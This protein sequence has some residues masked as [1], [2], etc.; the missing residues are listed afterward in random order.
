MGKLGSEFY[1]DEVV[2]A[3]YMARRE[4]RADSPN[5]V[6]E[7]PILDELIGD[8][9]NLRILDLGCGNAE[10]GQEAFQRGCR[11]YLGIDGSENMINLAQNMLHGTSGKTERATIEE[12]EYPKSQFDLVISRLALHYIEPFESICT[13]VF[14]TLLDGGRFIFS[15]EHP[16]ITSSDQAWRT[17]GPRQHWIVDDYFE[18]G[19]RVTNWMGGDVIKYH[20][21]V[22]DYF[23]A[24]RRAK[25]VI[26]DVRES[27]PRR[28]LFGDEETYKRRKR[29]PLLLFFSAHRP[30]A[31]TQ[32]PVM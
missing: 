14:R 18:T 26:D 15:V 5:D 24:L 4:K 7:K 22:E 16:V 17:S 6:L 10:F 30:S 9:T 8:P 27:R 28:N 3:T 2:F 23:S 31:T 20:R 25:F 32:A 1:D 21:T 12:W 11:S 13:K 19:R 29:I